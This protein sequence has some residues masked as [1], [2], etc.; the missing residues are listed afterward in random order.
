[1]GPATNATKAIGPA[2]ATPSA[3]RATPTHTSASF[4]RETRS[5]SAAAMS[6]P[7]SN[8]SS[9]RCITTASGPS[10]SRASPTMR[11]CSHVRPFSEPVSQTAARW[12]SVILARVMRKSINASIANPAPMPTS[13][14][15]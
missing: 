1:M 15:R 11:T 4:D 13:T 6:S 10:T 12:T 5:P 2:A 3:A 8:R 14:R 7:N 9:E